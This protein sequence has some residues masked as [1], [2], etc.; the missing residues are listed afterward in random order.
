MK[1]QFPAAG[2]SPAYGYPPPSR[3]PQGGGNL[4]R[5]FDN[6]GCVTMVP[7][8]PKRPSSGL[9]LDVKAVGPAGG[10]TGLFLGAPASRERLEVAGLRLSSSDCTSDRIRHQA[11]SHVHTSE[12]RLMQRKNSQPAVPYG[13]MRGV[14][15]VPALGGGSG[16]GTSPLAPLTRRLPSAKHNMLPPI[17]AEPSDSLVTEEEEESLFGTVSQHKLEEK[18]VGG[19]A[20]SAS[21]DESDSESDDEVGVADNMVGV[22]SDA[23]ISFIGFLRDGI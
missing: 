4:P 22:V 21:D 3:G 11:T 18:E 10:A 16:T 20:Q 7:L 6:Q 9:K 12:G 13:A 2:P 17:G 14:V 1:K 19:A 15:P 23:L 8:R 5:L